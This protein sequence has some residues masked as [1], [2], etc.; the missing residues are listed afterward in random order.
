MVIF[1]FFPFS[2]KKLRF[3][4]FKLSR[5]FEPSQTPP[6]HTWVAERTMSRRHRLI[7]HL[8]LG[9]ER[10][11]AWRRHTV[12]PGGA[13]NKK[14]ISVFSLKVVANYLNINEMWFKLPWPNILLDFWTLTVREEKG[15][16]FRHHEN[17]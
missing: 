13:K 15:R 7:K 11:P 10:A 17:K 9:F 3:L 2:Q 16:H 12:I 8:F 4:C 14:N 1:Y 5:N 6:H